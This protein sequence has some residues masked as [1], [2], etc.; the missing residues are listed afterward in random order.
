ME[1]EKGFKKLT[2]DYK[3]DDEYISEDNRYDIKVKNQVYAACKIM[4][5]QFQE[6]GYFGN[7]EVTDTITTYT[8]LL[9]EILEVKLKAGMLMRLNDRETE[10][11]RHIKEMD[12]RKK[13]ILDVIRKIECAKIELNAILKDEESTWNKI[14]E[15]GIYAIRSLRDGKWV[16]D[17]DD[18]ISNL[19][20]KKKKNHTEKAMLELMDA[21]EEDLLKKY[22]E[23]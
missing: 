16:G 1:N 14:E 7:T 3:L 10:K 15:F 21:S 8:A 5:F 18:H 2:K 22:V 6:R 13:K 23:L 20:A 4:K 11:N 9:D 17:Y 19:R 12:I